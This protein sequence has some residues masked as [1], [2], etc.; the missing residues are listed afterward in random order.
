MKTV[1]EWVGRMPPKLDASPPRGET[2]PPITRSDGCTALT[3][4][5]VRA[6]SD[7]YAGAAA[8]EPSSLNC[9]SQKR[10]RFGSLPTISPASCG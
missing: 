5:Y 10:F 8:S 7:S 1:G 9:G 2:A 3:A 4:S 6:S